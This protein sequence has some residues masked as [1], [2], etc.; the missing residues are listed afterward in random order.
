MIKTSTDNCISV[1][2]QQTL[3]AYGQVKKWT[4]SVIPTPTW[5]YAASNISVTSQKNVLAEALKAEKRRQTHAWNKY[6]LT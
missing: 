1:G 4:F 3:E 2:E 5:P 6:P